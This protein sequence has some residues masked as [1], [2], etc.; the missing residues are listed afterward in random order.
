MNRRQTPVAIARY[1]TIGLLVAMLLQAALPST[2]AL[3]S[4]AG[5]PG[6]SVQAAQALTVN[7]NGPV[8]PFSSHMLGQAL[9]NWE[10]SWGRPFPN[11]V[12]GLAQAMREAGAGLIRYAG[13]NWANDVGFERAP[14]RTP[15]TAW[16]KNG[17]TY[18]FHYGTDELDSLNR[19]ADAVGAEVMIQVNLRLYDPAMW[20]DMVRYTNVER[21]YRFQYWELGN[22]LD[23]VPSISPETYVA[24]A[25]VYA[26]A[27]KAVDPSIKIVAAVPGSAH[28]SP[29]LGY[30]DSV[31]ALSEFLTQSAQAAAPPARTI[32][33][34]S[35]HWYQACNSTNTQDI[36]L[37]SY[38]GLP[39][40]SWRSSYSRIWSDIIPQR[41]DNEAIGSR[42]PIRQGITELNFDACNYDS[43]RNGNHLTALWA[44]DVIGRL[45]YRGVDFLTWYEGYA[46]QAYSLIY[47]DNGDNPS[48]LFLRP[49]YSAFFLYSKYFGNQMV[50]SQ[51]Y[52][53]A[54]V[55]IWASTDS[56]DPGK[57]KL[58]VT[59]L[60]GAPITTPVNL[61]GFTAATG[62]VYVLSSTSPTDTGPSSVT[63]QAPTTI[64]GVRLSGANV[65]L[66]ASAIQPIGLAINGAS[67][68]YTF[69]AYSSVAMVLTAA[70]PTPSSTRTPTRTPSPTVRPSA[71]PTATLGPPSPTA[72]R[73]PSPQ[74]TRTDTP[75]PQ[76]NVAVTVGPVGA[77]RLPVVLEARGPGCAPNN[78]LLELRFGDDPRVYR[79]AAI[80]IDGQVRRPPFSV[81]LP[82]DTLARAFAVVQLAGGSDATV[83]VIARDTCG[84]WST[85]VGGGASVFESTGA[86]RSSTSGASPTA[87]DN[88]AGASTAPA[89]ASATPVG[90]QPPR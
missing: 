9:V 56:R 72:T 19:L 52:N 48:R 10:H 30:S 38:A 49:S 50:Q 25:R 20:A 82:P 54:D 36:L 63:E 90:G 44:S 88:P 46:T 13:G 28:D 12:P 7:A 11:E 2:A 47:P 76:P 71:S 55:S 45:A 61:A 77:G 85:F 79:N 21:G 5:E 31:T 75:L 23:F 37:W 58:R 27:M 22:E 68:V 69:P 3:L 26:D 29:R 60:T 83:P 32:D 87:A 39:T 66:S 59:N 70:G 73:T 35:Y 42:G 53:E 57:L 80:E 8:N 1:G 24:R 17:N 16:S 6:R 74:P 78:R 15:Y 89:T 18:S 51:S 33:E 14:Q 34:L 64:N 84:E 41:V 4:P 62:Q 81:V 43:T 65:A 86:S 40:N 67:F